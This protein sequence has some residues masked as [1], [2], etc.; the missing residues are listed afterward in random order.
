MNPEILAQKKKLTEMQPHLTKH[1]FSIGSEKTIT[2]FRKN[3]NLSPSPK[4]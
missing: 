3:F 2:D 4:Q 1:F